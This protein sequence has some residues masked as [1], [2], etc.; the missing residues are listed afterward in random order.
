MQFASG[1][2]SEG[3]ACA[4]HVP[5]LGTFSLFFFCLLASTGQSW[6]GDYDV[7][8]GA[9][10][11]GAEAVGSVACRFDKVCSAS[12]EALGLRLSIDV[13]P[14]DPRSAQIRLYGSDPSCCYFAGAADSKTIDLGERVSKVPF[15]RGRPARRLLLIQNEYVGTL[16]IRIRRR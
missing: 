3:G 16:Y 6:A 13:L 8:Y 14:Y 12:I 10:V 9:E 11:R 4:R 7:D 2:L 1:D 5:W 15:Y